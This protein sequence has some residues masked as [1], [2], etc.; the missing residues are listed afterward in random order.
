MGD[1]ISIRFVTG[2]G[3]SAYLYSHWHGLDVLEDVK[4]YVARLDVEVPVAGTYPLQRREADAVMADFLTTA[5][6]IEVDSNGHVMSGW[7]ITT[8]PTTATLIA[9]S[10]RMGRSAS[11]RPQHEHLHSVRRGAAIDRLGRNDT[12]SRPLVL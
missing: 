10:V 12:A 5:E 1:R 6:V 8:Y 2:D 11:S 3:E 4:A 9:C 7:R